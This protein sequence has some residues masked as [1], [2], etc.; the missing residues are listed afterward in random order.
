MCGESQ[1]LTVHRTGAILPPD[2]DSAPNAGAG[3]RG[4]PEVPLSEVWKGPGGEG[5]RRSVASRLAFAGLLGGLA[6]LSSGCEVFS[7][8]QNTFAPEGEVA[9][10]QKFAFLLT[11]WPALAVMLLVELGLLFMMLRF[12]RRDGDDRLPK[13]IH[14]N[15]FLEISWTIAPAILLALFVPLVVAGIFK[16]G[17]P[18][19]D[20][21]RIEVNAFRFGWVFDYQ[22]PDGTLVSGGATTTEVI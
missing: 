16:L 22:A 19:D 1:P 17:T 5:L 13:Q 10:F 7:S 9:E 2:L 4:A 15:N 3:V 14:G 18:P 8:P 20:S 12:R 21:L 6:I 11:L